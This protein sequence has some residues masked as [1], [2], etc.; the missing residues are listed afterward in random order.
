MARIGILF[1]GGAPK[2]PIF[3]NVWLYCKKQLQ[4]HKDTWERCIKMLDVVS[5]NRR[6]TSRLTLNL[7]GKILLQSDNKNLHETIEIIDISYDGLQIVF[8]KNTFLFDFL[9]AKEDS[10]INIMTQFEYQGKM[11]SFEHLIN[12]TRIYNFG[13]KDYYVLSCLKFKNREKI[14]EILLELILV[15]Q[16]ACADKAY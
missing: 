3:K 4:I 10:D 6:K 12:W 14:K 15:V 8:S 7:H 1:G 9:E 13:E 16:I 5:S 2:P 11:F